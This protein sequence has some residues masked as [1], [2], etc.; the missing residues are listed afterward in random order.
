MCFTEKEILEF[1]KFLFIKFNLE[2]SMFKDR[3]IYIKAKSKFLFR[4]L[5]LPYMHESMMYK[6]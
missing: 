1:R 5:V 6:L 3:R 2:T 4:Q